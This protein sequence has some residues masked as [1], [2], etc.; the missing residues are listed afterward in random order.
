MAGP[1]RASVK[2]KKTNT[3]PVKEQDFV[4]LVDNVRYPSSRKST[5]VAFDEI[6]RRM[7]Q[8][9]KQ[10]AYNFRIPGF[11]NA[12]IYQESLFALRYKAI[13][14]YDQSRG[15][16]SGPYPFDRFAVLCIRRH[17]MTKLKSSYQNK[18][19]VVNIAVSLDQERAHEADE[20]LC[21]A[22]IIPAPGGNVLEDVGDNEYYST[23]I[24][25]LME[26][27]STFEKS[28]LFLYKQKYSY[29]QISDIINRKRRE[30]QKTQ[31]TNVKSIDNALSRI[32]SKA[33][34]VFSRHG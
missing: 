8:R 32:K 17:L 25:R 22:D 24:G 30:Q 19:K 21:L 33:V 28:V 27:L 2:R 34:A 7:D 26:R 18:Q 23:L 14:D 4:S 5:E 15:N 11:G 31:R 13:K 10:I 20:A 3:T 29:K 6:V 12:D 16:R 9:L 1:K